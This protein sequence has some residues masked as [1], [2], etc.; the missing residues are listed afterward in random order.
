[1]D[2]RLLVTVWLTLL[3]AACAAPYQLVEP[4]DVSIG[5]MTVTI[6]GNWNQASTMQTPYSRKNARVWTLDG[7]L[8]DRLMIIPGIANGETVFISD[9]KDAA[10]PKFRSDMLPFEISELVESSLVKVLGE[11]QVS[12]STSGLRP[13]H[14]GNRPGA[15]FELN[16]SVKDGPDYEGFAGGFVADEKLYLVIFLGAHPYYSEKN[17][18]AAE[19]ILQSAR[20]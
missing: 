10:L 18:H 15:F 2:H 19:S 5:G 4:G 8:L 6:D 13:Q 7:L 20:L 1:M 11:G 16:A 12:V 9:A 17:R 3:V 14:F